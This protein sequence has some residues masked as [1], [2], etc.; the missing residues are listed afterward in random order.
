MTELAQSLDQAWHYFANTA[1]TVSYVP[2]GYG[3]LRW[4]DQPI[5]S[6]EVRALYVHLR[7]L[8]QHHQLRRVL[9]DHRQMHTM[10]VDD[11]H[12]LLTE[13]LPTTVALTGYSHCAVLPTLDPAH[14]LHSADVVAVL[15]NYISVGIFE[16]LPVASTWLLR[17][18]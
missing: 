3:Y 10:S 8:L 6:E 9:A 2:G 5:T 11:K 17:Q 13:W 1:G 7:N 12:W 15:Q 18:E 4:H 14:R 16:E